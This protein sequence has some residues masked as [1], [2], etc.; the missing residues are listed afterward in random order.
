MSVFAQCG[1]YMGGNGCVFLQFLRS[2]DLDGT[3][4]TEFV[5]ERKEMLKRYTLC[6]PTL[7]YG[8]D[9]IYSVFL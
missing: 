2:L 5:N 7:L 4:R 1:G 3:I 6:Q 9:S 8:I